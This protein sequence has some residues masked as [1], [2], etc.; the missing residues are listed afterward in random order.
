MSSDADE[1]NTIPTITGLFQSRTHSEAM[2]SSLIA[3]A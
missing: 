1:H 2:D 3:T